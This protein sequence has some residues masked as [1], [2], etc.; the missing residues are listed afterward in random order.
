MY[1]YVQIAINGN[2]LLAKF[3]FE[4]EMT[5]CLCEKY[6]AI[7]QYIKSILN[8]IKLYQRSLFYILWYKSI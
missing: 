4:D 7:L 5:N 6:F 3:L 1:I 8:F 2:L